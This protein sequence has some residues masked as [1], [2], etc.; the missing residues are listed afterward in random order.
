VANIK[1]QQ[2]IDLAVEEA[3]Y[4]DPATWQVIDE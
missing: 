3:V 2:A 1:T 4:N